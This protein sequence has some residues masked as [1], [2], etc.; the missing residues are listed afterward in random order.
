MSNLNSTISFIIFCHTGMNVLPEMITDINK[1]II[2]YAL[3]LEQ[4]GIYSQFETDVT[5]L[6]VYNSIAKEFDLL[7]LTFID[8]IFNQ[9]NLD[10]NFNGLLN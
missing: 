2:L 7:P 5:I 9:S 1:E 3:Q 10:I 8:M 4:E 6:E